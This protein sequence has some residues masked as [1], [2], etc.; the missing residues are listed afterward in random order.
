MKVWRYRD[1]KIWR[2]EDL[3]VWKLGG[4]DIWGFGDIEIWMFGFL[5][6]WIF[7]IYSL[8]TQFYKL[9]DR[10]ILLTINFVVQR[11]LQA[12]NLDCIK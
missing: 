11:H 9:N 10:V 1:L 7:L 3:E 6:I 8:L 12:S 5:V 4:L 2:F